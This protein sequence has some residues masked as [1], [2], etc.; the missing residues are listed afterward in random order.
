MPVVYNLL[1]A[2]QIIRFDE[3]NYYTMK[4]KIHI[5]S[6]YDQKFQLHLEVIVNIKIIQRGLH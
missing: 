1:F 6:T 3:Y 5:L 4:G 2:I